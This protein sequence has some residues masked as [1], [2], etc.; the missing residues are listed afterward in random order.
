MAGMG[1]K[2]T[3]ALSAF[4]LEWVQLLAMRRPPCEFLRE[5][6]HVDLVSLLERQLPD[7]VLL[8]VMLTA[9]TDGPPVRR[10]QA[11]TAVGVAMD[12]RAFDPSI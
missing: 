6:A 4:W 12:M 9:K 8:D 1:R 7:L 10:L 5:F 3:L 2:Q 11:H